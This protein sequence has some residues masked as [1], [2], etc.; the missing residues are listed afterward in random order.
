MII[1]KLVT[2]NRVNISYARSVESE[3]RDAV[4]DSSKLTNLS[5]IVY[6]LVNKQEIPL[7]LHCKENKASFKSFQKGYAPFCGIK[8]ANKHNASIQ[9]VTKQLWD[10][11]RVEQIVDKR[12]KTNFDK[13]GTINAA[14]SEQAKIKSK[15]TCVTKYGVEFSSQSEIKKQKTKETC[16]NK[17]GVDNPT[18][19]PEIKQKAL[20]TIKSKYGVGYYSTAQAHISEDIINLLYDPEWLRYQHHDLKRSPRTIA[21]DLNVDS[22]V[23][24]ERLERFGIEK[25]DYSDTAPETI[26]SDILNELGVNYIK[27]DRKILEGKELDFYIPDHN[28][29]IEYNGLYYHSYGTVPD[30]TQ[31]NRHFYKFEQCEKKGIQLIQYTGNDFIK[32][33]KFIMAK[34]GMLPKIYGRSC[35]VDLIDGLEFR[36]ILNANHLQGYTN[37]QVKIGLKY[38]DNIIGVMGFNRKNDDWILARMAFDGVSVIGGA[39][40][41]LKWF[42]NNYLGNIISYSS[43]SYSDGNVYKKLG[44]EM[45]ALH[46]HDLWYTNGNVLFNRQNFQKHTLSSK[47]PTFNPELTEV[48][49]MLNNKYRVY[50]GPGTK[51]WLLKR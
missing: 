43:N 8:C 25:I 10:D 26:I 17:Y 42:K 22:T 48:Q 31:K 49:N 20:D 5:E 46:K 19:L 35:N 30:F 3:L 41:M 15:I 1:E 27:K 6:I 13:Y 45:T 7:C 9:S 37:C 4:E 40:K 16:L 2:K 24:Y 36:R 51:T 33:Q 32:F 14:N 50:Y 23:I 11:G 29:A 38:N 28:L 21:L 39:S 18:K 47:L 12:R 44:F 34:L